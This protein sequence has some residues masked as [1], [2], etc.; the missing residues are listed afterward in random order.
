MFH[1]V[2][3]RCRCGLSLCKYELRGQVICLGLLRGKRLILLAVEALR[4]LA[5]GQ[6]KANHSLRADAIEC[7]IRACRK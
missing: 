7:I 1:R 6:L 3:L 2:S 4:V 5:S